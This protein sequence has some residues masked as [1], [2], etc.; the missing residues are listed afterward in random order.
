MEKEPIMITEE[1][2]KILL[3]KY[4]NNEEKLENYSIIS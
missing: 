2:Y 1:E 3:D 4:N